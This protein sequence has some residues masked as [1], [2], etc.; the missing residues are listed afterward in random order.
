MGHSV[1]D[2]AKYIVCPNGRSKSSLICH[3]YNTELHHRKSS[4]C[5]S[6]EKNKNK[7]NEEE[8]GEEK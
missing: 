4:F 2:K 8:R 5:V 6:E 7:K 3:S 1:K